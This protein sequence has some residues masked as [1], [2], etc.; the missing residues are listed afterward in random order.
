[1]GVAKNDY[2]VAVALQTNRDYPHYLVEIHQLV[3]GYL[4]HLQTLNMSVFNNTI[5]T[6]SSGSVAMNYQNTLA[7]SGTGIDSTGYVILYAPDDFGQFTMRRFFQHSYETQ[8]HVYLTDN[9][10]MYITSPRTIRFIYCTDLFNGCSEYIKS[11]FYTYSQSPYQISMGYCGLT[12]LGI[13]KDLA[14]ASCNSEKIAVFTQKSLS[15]AWILAK[16]ITGASVSNAPISVSSGGDRI[17]IGDT[18][19][20]SAYRASSYTY[21]ITIDY[22]QDGVD[23]TKSVYVGHDKTG[24]L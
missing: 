5:L 3:E 20:V 8:P 1:M 19:K 17:L 13:D 16:I 22:S 4:S 12:S 18:G 7:I 2:Y 21:T 6:V 23:T 14:A 11:T 10:L 9:T 24:E 15:G